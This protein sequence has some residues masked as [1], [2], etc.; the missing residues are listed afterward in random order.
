MNSKIG[1]SHLEVDP[2]TAHKLGISQEDQELQIALANYV[3]G[4]DAEK[5]LLRKIDL[6]LM[7]ILWIMYVLNYIDR[8]NIVSEVA[9]FVALLPN[10]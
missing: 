7:P 5:K 3:P 1:V 9:S 4:S 8:T 2:T 10:M 6:R